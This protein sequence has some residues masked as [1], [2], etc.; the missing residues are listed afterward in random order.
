MKLGSEVFFE[1][2]TALYK[3]RRIGLLTNLTGVNQ[4]LEATIDLFAKHEDLNL[5]VLFGP[6]H[7]IRGE[8]R[9]GEWVESSVDPSTNVPVYSLYNADKT[10]NKEMLLN[11]DVVF[12]DLQDIGSRYYTFIY[13]MANVM[14]LCK[15]EGKQFVVLDR[16]NPI[17]GLGVEGN[18][19][20]DGYHSF[21]GQYSIPVRHGMTI[22]ELAYMFNTE[23]GI[24]CELDVIEM[25][26][27]S[28]EHYFDETG[29][30]W[31]SPTPNAT[32][33]DMCLL[34]P[35]I[36]LIEGTNI[37]EGRGT[38]KPFEVIGAPFIDGRRLA[39]ELS[40]SGLGGVIFRPTVFK[41][42]FNKF[43]G[44]VCEGVQ[45][46]ITNRSTLKPYLVGLTLIKVLRELY[47]E[48]LEFIKSK[49][50]NNAFFLDLLAGTNELR[51]QLIEGD[52]VEFKKNSEHDEILFL[53]KRASYLL[54]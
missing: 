48:K 42:M 29:L 26:E 3:N 8:A 52:I 24:G 34:Y 27:W 23:F 33:V 50:F 44:E 16:P 49:D 51:E 1:K 43:V 10:P 19:V 25:S 54:Y 11:V 14:K 18:S 6:E 21:V 35:G 28:R 7:G 38:T 5:T 15:E 32:G 37:S 17:N 12:C 30:Y 22:G 46:H 41:P 47:P 13:T 2:H 40:L 31:V 45:I 20:Q 53:A 9:E 39:M 4:K 36:C